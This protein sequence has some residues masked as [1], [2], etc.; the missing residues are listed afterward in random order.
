MD[1]FELETELKTLRPR[2]L[3][4]RLAAVIASASELPRASAEILPWDWRRWLGW[5]CAAVILFG[6]LSLAVRQPAPAATKAPVSRFVP[7]DRRTVVLER[8]EDEGFVPLADGSAARRYRIHSADI[9]T[10]TDPKTRASVRWIVPREDVQI[11]PV[12]VY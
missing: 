5:S 10:W 9:V 12:R 7:T 2:R 11:V 1:D 4:P 8:E 6:L 3:P